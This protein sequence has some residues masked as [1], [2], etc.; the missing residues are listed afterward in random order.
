VTDGKDHG[1][2]AFQGLLE[3]LLHSNVHQLI[4]VAEKL[5]F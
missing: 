4:L 2:D 3:V 5:R 1:L